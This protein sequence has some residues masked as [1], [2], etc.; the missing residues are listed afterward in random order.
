MLVVYCKGTGSPASP[1]GASTML[2]RHVPVVCGFIAM[3]NFFTDAS[4]VADL[5]AD[6]DLTLFDFLTFQNAFAMGCG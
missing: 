2:A 4:P 1:T 3:Q 6:G 5:D